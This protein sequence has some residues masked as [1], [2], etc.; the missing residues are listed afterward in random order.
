MMDDYREVIQLS[1]IEVV[2]IASNGSFQNR[3]QVGSKPGFGHY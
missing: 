1:R 2:L 3:F